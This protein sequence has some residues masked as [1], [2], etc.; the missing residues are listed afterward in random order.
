MRIGSLAARYAESAEVSLSVLHVTQPVDGGVA[1][2]VADLVADQVGRGWRVGVV[3][4]QGGPL[5]ARVRSIGADHLAWRAYRAPGAR[6]PAETRAVS[7]IAKAWAPDLVHLHSSKAGLAGRLALRGR[8]PTLF[9]PHAWS[10]FAVGEPLRT[11]ARGWERATARWADAIVC[12]SEGERAAGQ[13]AGIR[14]EWRV[15]PNGI[16]LDA[17]RPAS[18]RERTKARQELGLGPGPVAVCLGRLCRQKG[19]D[20]LVDAWPAVVRRVP[21]AELVLV[22]GGPADEVVRERARVVGEQEDVRSWLA[23]ADVVVQPSRWEG[24]AYVVLEAMASGRS[25]VATDVPGMREALGETGTIVPP[26]DP[27]RLAE[28]VAD[29]LLDGASGEAGRERVEALFG[30][31]RATAAMAD[32]YAEVLE[33]R[34]RRQ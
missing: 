4:P 25:V 14:S 23:A 19:Q 5:L 18:D 7:R 28:A 34:A 11:A 21:Q 24:L 1:R 16:D 31:E 33:S 22:G 26:E 8:L 32:L 15:V 12:V 27:L 30:V 10:F 13:Q 2:C 20:V 6:V 9:Q 29:R 3:C 17:F